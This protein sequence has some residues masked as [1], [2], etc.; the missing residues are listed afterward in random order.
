[1][2]VEFIDVHIWMFIDAS[3]N[4]SCFRIAYL[5]KSWFKFRGFI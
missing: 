1:M 4:N 3:N 2:I 5:N